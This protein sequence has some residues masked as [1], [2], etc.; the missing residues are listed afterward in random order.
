MRVKLELMKK[1]TFPLEEIVKIKAQRLS[2]LVY[3][4]TRAS[5]VKMK[6]GEYERSV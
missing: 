5:S 6:L 1:W 3:G 4:L 2:V